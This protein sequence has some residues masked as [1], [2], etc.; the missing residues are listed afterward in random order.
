M[1]Q[2]TNNGFDFSVFWHNF[3]RTFPRMVWI[4]LLLCLGLGAFQYYRAVR[5]YTPLYETTSVYRVTSGR[6]GS[7]DIGS[8]YSIYLDS[9]AAANLANSYP[10]VM[11]SDYAKDLLQK[12]TGQRSLPASVTCR[13]ENTFLVF[14]ASS[15]NPENVYLALQTVA[16]VFPE[17]ARAIRGSFILDPFEPLEVPTEPVN[18]RNPIPAAAKGAG[19]GFLLGLG[20][21]CL[22]AY[23][24]RT[25]HNSLDLRE[26]V[27]VPCLGLLPK[28]R[29]KARTRQDSTVLLSN[30]HLEESYA[31]AIRGVRFQLRKELEGQNI[32]VIMVTSTS[33]GEGK[34]TISANLALSLADQGNRVVLVDCDLRMQALKKVFGV[35][36]PTF[37]LTDLISGRVEDVDSALVSVSDSGLRL[38][39]GDKTVAQPQNF[40][41]GPKVQEIVNHLRQNADYIIVDTPPSGLLADA[42][43]LG[44]WVDG[45]IYV[46]RQDYMSRSAILNS[47]QSL[48][49][50]DVR[51]LGCVINQC[52][53]STSSSGY[54]YGARKGEGYGYGYGYGYGNYGKKNY[55]K[56]NSAES[57][58]SYQK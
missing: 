6:G 21:I 13:A 4:P 5:S 14:S 1:E 49:G 12:K 17:A 32:Q 28:V 3:A 18:T 40:L 7:L 54:G 26:L 22:F 56:K 25:I 50:M 51:F 37:G 39:S 15:A 48:N 23:F 9:N 30:P 27:N 19:L 45:T 10:Y 29:F 55:G 58:D 24:R 31:E 53:R 36:T 34:S 11:N 42:S 47:V 16:D 8:T 52:V 38:L 46:V 2:K 41:S 43:T 57:S 44:E 35:S 20:L 33:P